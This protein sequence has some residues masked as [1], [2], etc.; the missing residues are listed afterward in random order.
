MVIVVFVYNND[1]L[2]LPL[3]KFKILTFTKSDLMNRP[4]C[5]THSLLEILPK[6]AF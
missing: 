6:N 1:R 5:L 4:G 2:G 3:I